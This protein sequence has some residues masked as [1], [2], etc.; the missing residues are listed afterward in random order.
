[1]KNIVKC[2]KDFFGYF[3]TLETHSDKSR[4]IWVGQTLQLANWSFL[5]GPRSLGKKKNIFFTRRF[6]PYSTEKDVCTGPW[7]ETQNR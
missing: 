4:P 5:E 2:Y 1:M 7:K 3:N 6:I